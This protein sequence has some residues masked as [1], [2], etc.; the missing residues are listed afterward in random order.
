MNNNKQLN[1]EKRV[2]TVLP[3]D[4]EN[5]LI[6]IPKNVEIGLIC[7]DLNPT[8]EELRRKEDL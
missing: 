3:I 6:I 8:F 5:A 4:A 7:T 1:I 2:S